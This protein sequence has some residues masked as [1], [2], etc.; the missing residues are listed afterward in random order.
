[1]GRQQVAQQLDA[2]SE[3]SNALTDPD[4][5]S[6]PIT[7]PDL[8][9]IVF[10]GSLTGSALYAKLD[11]PKD[12]GF[13]PFRT[14]QKAAS[15]CNCDS[16]WYKLYFN[17]LQLVASA[18]CFLD[19]FALLWDPHADGGVGDIM[20]KPGVNIS[21]Q[22][23]PHGGQPNGTPGGQG[24]P[25]GR[26][27]DYA[28]DTSTTTGANMYATIQATL[29]SEHNYSMAQFR[30][31]AYDF[32]L[33]PKQWR[34]ERGSGQLYDTGLFEEMRGVFQETAA[35]LG[36]KPLIMSLSEGG[37]VT[38]CFLDYM[39]QS[40]KDQYVEGWISY[41][42]VFAG[43]VQM[44]WNQMSG[45]P[46]Y[47]EMVKSTTRALQC[48]LWPGSAES[49]PFQGFATFTTPQFQY[50]LQNFPGQAVVS[51]V[52]TGVTSDIEEGADNNILFY[53]PSRNYTY[54]EYLEAVRDNGLQNV[55]QVYESLKPPSGS[56]RMNFDA[57]GVRTWCIYGNLS[58]PIGLKYDF[59]FNG[60]YNS[61]QPVSF[62]NGDGD[63]T[64]HAASLRV[65]DRWHSPA[66]TTGPI[67]TVHQFQGHTHSGILTDGLG[68]GTNPVMPLINTAIREILQS[69]V[70]RR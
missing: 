18:P 23:G 7:N 35:T 38:K 61:R 17:P 29:I 33:G 3:I 28:G 36:Q 41:S 48:Q 40:W 2:V 16:D 8:P 12:Q 59:D 63:G 25:A 46:Y 5:L 21:T 65:C 68:T 30:T 66:Q 4:P 39:D 27:L 32:R 70:A 20:G 69:N 60:T 19:N 55:A 1:L 14:C 57:P 11:K 56:L 9:P 58:T 64:V 53:T 50:A 10:V 34:A 52:A 47:T 43:A 24:D 13:W 31:I 44:A 67:T 42:G 22:N 37:T 62:V 26:G 6:A 45:L 54:T 51:P 15:R 49:C